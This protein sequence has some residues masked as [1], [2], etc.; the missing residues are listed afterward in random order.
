MGP[1]SFLRRKRHRGH[2]HT[3]QRPRGHTAK[4]RGCR[5]N[6]ACLLDLTLLAPRTATNTV[7]L[8]NP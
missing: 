4:G 6:P 1:A 8:Y 7:L 3:E 5:R 2:T